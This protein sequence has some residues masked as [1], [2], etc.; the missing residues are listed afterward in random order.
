[1]SAAALRRALDLLE[2]GPHAS[3]DQ[4]VE[5]LILGANGTA[6]PVQEVAPTSAALGGDLARLLL[7]PDQSSTPL[8]DPVEP[9]G[10][11]Q[12]LTNRFGPLKLAT[13]VLAN[14][15]D[16]DGW[17][18]LVAF[19]AQAS[20]L[21]RSVGRRLRT[22]DLERGRRGSNR[23]WIAYPVGE[24][25]RAAF[26]RYVFSFTLVDGDAGA[27]GPLAQLGLAV[28]ENG[29]AAL[30][31]RGWELA[32]APSPTLD[33]EGTSTLSADEVRILRTAV[34][35]LPDEAA[36]IAEF[37]RAVRVAAGRQA[38]VD[39]LLGAWHGDWTVDRA[40][41][42]RSA[43]LGRLGELGVLVVNGRGPTARIELTDSLE[44]E[45]N[46]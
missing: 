14:L 37:L 38:R 11:L 33:G 1:L 36:A 9:V 35:D 40:A 2:A 34:H 19:H 39:E 27:A 6:V 8:A 16:E 20:A 18:E 21:A 22:E 46:E 43:M 5:T 28:I 13:R 26:G 29:R 23:R 17:P 15:V 45:E 3:L 4:L 31:R 10:Q 7:R 24:D 30:T 25:E 12:F 41:A 42:E 44:F 32:A